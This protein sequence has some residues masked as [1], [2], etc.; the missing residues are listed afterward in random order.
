MHTTLTVWIKGCTY[1]HVQYPQLKLVKSSSFSYNDKRGLYIMGYS[2][3]SCF[4]LHL[5]YTFKAC[6]PLFLRS[7]NSTIFQTIIQHQCLKKK[8]NNGRFLYYGRELAG[9]PVEWSGGWLG[10]H[11]DSAAATPSHHCQ[12]SSVYKRGSCVMTRGDVRLKHIQK[13]SRIWLSIYE[14]CS[15]L[16]T[17]YMYLTGSR[18]SS[19]ISHAFSRSSGDNNWKCTKE[20]C[21]F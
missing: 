19:N 15:Y 18:R 12:M 21:L 11:H 13:C 4:S 20:T 6:P 2:C 14:Q 9:W 5:S 8:Q 3:L 16:S 10:L 1:I 7:F 17:V